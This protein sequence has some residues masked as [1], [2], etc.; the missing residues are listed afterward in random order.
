MVRRSLTFLLFEVFVTSPFFLPSPSADAAPTPTPPHATPAPAPP[1]ATPKLASPPPVPSPPAPLAQTEELWTFRTFAAKDGLAHDIVRD[2]LEADH[3]EIWF[4]T[5]G[6]ITRYDPATC[7]YRS[8]RFAVAARRRV[9][10]LAR[11]HDRAIWAATQGGGIGRYAEGRWRWFTAKD[12]LP[13]QEAVTA[14]LV[15]HHGQIW[16]TPTGGG[17]LVYNGK[18]WRRHGPKEGLDGGELGHCIETRAGAILCATYDP[19]RLRR[20]DGHHWATIPVEDVAGREFYVHDLLEARDGHIWLATKGAGV[21]VG[22]PDPQTGTYRWDVPKALHLASRRVGAIF[23]AG[24]GRLWFATAGGVSVFDGQRTRSFSRADGLGSS[25]V[26]A[27]S[28]TRDGAL[29]FATLGGGASRYG[30]SRW[31]REGVAQGLPSATISG[32]L[33][34][35]ASGAIWAGTDQG[36]ARRHRGK[37]LW[38]ALPSGTPTRDQVTDLARDPRGG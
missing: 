36:L 23:A 11:G 3:G 31:R 4:A 25:H 15:D 12:G 24:D 33:L 37:P 34:R 32:G 10:A 38:T 13:P 1:R 26:F 20:Y 21:I 8:F 28:Q 7:R 27:I 30:P 35:D 18:A 6:G 5:M 14:L 22:V 17:L 19:K 29:W 2:L 16:A 9:M